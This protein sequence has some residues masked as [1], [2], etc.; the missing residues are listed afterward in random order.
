MKPYWES[1]S[2]LG[3]HARLSERNI[4]ITRLVNQ[5]TTVFLIFT[6]LSNKLNEIFDTF[7]RL[8]SSADYEVSGLGLATC[9]KIVALHKGKIDVSST[10]GKGT[11]FKVYLKAS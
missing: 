10:I 11:T 1:I 9:K 6:M 5:F 8:H 2:N 7:N 4:R 3:V